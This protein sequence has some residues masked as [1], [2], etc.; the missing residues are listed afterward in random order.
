MRGPNHN[1]SLTLQP[2]E[3][4]ATQGHLHQWLRLHQYQGVLAARQPELL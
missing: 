1:L 2:A 4:G 3:H